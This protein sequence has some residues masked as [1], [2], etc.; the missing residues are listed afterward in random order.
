MR[1]LVC[2]S[3]LVTLAC[4]GHDAPGA[5]IDHPRLQLDEDLVIA[6]PDSQP[7]LGV[8]TGVDGRLVAWSRNGAYLLSRTEAA[9]RIP[10]SFAGAPAGGAF[11][12][13]DILEFVDP[14]AA[15]VRHSTTGGERAGRPLPSGLRVVEAVRTERFGWVAAGVDADGQYRIQ[16]LD[17]SPWWVIRP[18][19]LRGGVLAPYRLAAARDG[20]LLTEAEPP[21]RTWRVGPEGAGDPFAP[22]GS[23]YPESSGV[24]RWVSAPVVEIGDGLVQTLADLASDR[25]VLVL[26]DRDGRELRKTVVGVPMALVGVTADGRHLVGVR[27]LGTPEVVLYRWGWRTNHP[28]GDEP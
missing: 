21:F 24:Q 25:R 8:A 26:Y 20:V 17:G 15:V 19:T 2:F 10:V 12:T 27:N 13:D 6:V 5:A 22:T 14:A 7:L 16:P 9:E 3:A 18:D 28:R 4:G 1:H 11:G 23:G